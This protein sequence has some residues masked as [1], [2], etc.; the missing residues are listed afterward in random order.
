M[1][2]DISTID[3][4]QEINEVLFK[5]NTL[6]KSNVNITSVEY[7][8]F[9]R[10]LYKCQIEKDNN[11]QLRAVLTIDELSSIVKNKNENSIKSLT[12]SL[13]KFIKIPI[14]FE[15]KKSYV[16]TTLINKVIVDK[17]TFN[18]NC[19]LDKDLYE[20]LMGY[21]ELGYSPINLKMI[22]QA[23]GYYTQRFYELFR[24]WSGLNKEVTYTIDKLKEWLMITEGMSYDRY[25]NFKIK[26]VEPSLKE[27]NKKLNMKV[28]YKE[29]KV[30]RSVKSLTFIVEDLEPRQYDFN[31]DKVIKEQISMDEIALDLNISTSD[32]INVRDDMDID[33]PES[34]TKVLLNNKNK[35]SD[36]T[37]KLK[38]SGIKIAISTINKFKTK[39]GEELVK[40]SV[41]ILCNKVKQQKITAPVKYL[42]GILEN[43]D[44]NSKDNEIN[45]DK[46]LKF[47][48][49]EPRQ[50]DYDELEK[51]LLGWDK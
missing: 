25:Y 2:S 41:D 31:K 29:N 11:Q 17:D 47:N 44:K 42:K 49:F 37:E 43:L 40:K 8:I 20:V 7:K 36:V 9:N 32:N 3:E 27:I 38:D 22:K 39:Y 24:V 48:N 5:S 45:N 19:Y 13:E 23:N 21:K 50:Y 10:I 33:L 6:I 16:I 28:S 14:R 4:G 26:V 46:K 30:G 35:F 1:N 51:K 12:E 18:F 34:K 15:K